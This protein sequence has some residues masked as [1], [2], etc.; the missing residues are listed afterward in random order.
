MKFIILSVVEKGSY[1]KCLELEYFEVF[2]FFCEFSLII[3]FGII[4]TKVDEL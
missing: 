2:F 3:K 4:S 1:K